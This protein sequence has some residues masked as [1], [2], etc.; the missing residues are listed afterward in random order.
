M[1]FVI[2]ALGIACAAT[3]QDQ[4][5]SVIDWVKRNP[6]QPAMTSAVLP[7]RFEAPVAPGVVVPEVTVQRIGQETQRLIGLVPGSVTGLPQHLWSGSTAEGLVAQLRDMPAL[8]LPAAQALL[9]TVLLTEATGP[10]GDT[11]GKDLLTLARADTLAR[12]GAHDPALALLEQAGVTRDTAHFAAYMDVAL[13]TGHED[14]ACAILDTNPHLAPSLGHR[15]FCAARQ[16]DWPT[17]ALLF[18][19]GRTLGSVKGADAAALERFLYPEAY[20]DAPP[21]PRPEQITPLVFRL[22]E[23]IGEPLPTGPLPRAYAV[24]DLRDLAGWKAQIEAAERLAV[25][26]A[27]PANRLL[28]LYTARQP[29][30]SGGVWDRVDAVQRLETALRTRSVEAISKSLPPAWAAMQAVGLE[31]IFADLFADSLARYALTGRAPEIAQTMALLAPTYKTTPLAD[32]TPALLRSVAQGEPADI[33]PSDP[34]SAAIVAGFEQQN[35]RSDLTTMARNG[36]M[37]EAILRALMLLDDGAS[38]DPVALTQSLAT[39][40]A[41]GLEDTARRAALQVLLLERYN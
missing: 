36:R 17:A 1:G 12:F 23:A 10:H 31:L 15:T 11:A 27:L 22:H 40:R 37:G 5:L 6:D 24:A 33:A 39:L 20:E 38:G 13:L 9:Y 29:A 3:A 8:K 41:F 4:P 2:C 30:A 14:A 25:T 19:T 32:A 28:G 35:A 21:L 7:P 34:R 26:G 16:G 18:D